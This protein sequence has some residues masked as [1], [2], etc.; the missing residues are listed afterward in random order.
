MAV[1]V[2]TEP[3]LKLGTPRSLFLNKY[4][5]IFDIHPDGERFLMLRLAEVGDDEST[6]EIAPK[7]NIVVNWFEELK[8]RVRVD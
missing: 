1:S 2:E 3:T 6:E 5:G 7:I 8:D 4:V